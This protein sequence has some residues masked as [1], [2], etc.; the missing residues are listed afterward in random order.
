MTEQPSGDATPA[1]PTFMQKVAKMEPREQATLGCLGIVGVIAVLVIGGWL[2][3]TLTGGSDDRSDAYYACVNAIDKD[4]LV[5]T[6]F[7]DATSYEGTD[8][9]WTIKG[10]FTSAG[11]TVQWTCN[12]ERISK[13]NYRIAWQ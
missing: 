3:S 1:E 12:A 13:G 10:T 5:Q 6:K 8:G 9:F 4:V 2:W 11:S 7:Q